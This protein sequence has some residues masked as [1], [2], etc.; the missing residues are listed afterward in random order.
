MSEGLTGL[1][2]WLSIAPQTATGALLRDWQAGV[3]KEVTSWDGFGSVER[4][5]SS[6]VQSKS[7]TMSDTLWSHRSSPSL[8]QPVSSATALFVACMNMDVPCGSRRDTQVRP[9]R[10]SGP[11]I[12]DFG[13]SM[14]TFDPGNQWPMR[15]LAHAE[16]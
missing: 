14:L 15:S 2:A 7:L 4:S 11:T 5:Q 1:G 9:E 8:A 13:R 12:R 3:A 6:L 10:C 16:W